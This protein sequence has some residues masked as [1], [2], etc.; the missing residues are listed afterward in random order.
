MQSKQSIVTIDKN[1]LTL[2][3]GLSSRQFA[4][5]KMGQYV[6]EP[7]VL[8]TQNAPNSF[9]TEE[10][11]FTDTKTLPVGK[12]DEVV[13]TNNTLQGTTLLSEIE[14]DSKKSLQALETLSSI[15]EWSI[16][17]N[18]QLP[19]CGPEGTIITKKG[20]LFLPFELFERSIL[21]QN[22]DTSSLLYGCWVNTALNDIDSWRFTLS[23]YTYTILT[24][25]KPF[26]EL[27]REKRT[28]DY[29]DNNFIPLNLMI[30]TNDTASQ[31]INHNLSLTNKAHTNIKPQKM[32][33]KKK[34]ITASLR[35][36]NKNVE[37]GS[38]A[39]PSQITDLEV[40]NIDSLILQSQQQF[41]EKK[42]KQLKKTRFLRKQKSKI[43]V[44]S[45]LFL[46]G[47]FI[48]GSIIKSNLS[49]PTTEGMTP[50]QVVQ[51]LYTSLN[52]LDNVTLDSCGTTDAVGNYSNMVATIYVSSKMREAYERT[53][54]FLTPSQW[55]GTDNPSEHFMFG[56]TNVTIEQ[57]GS[58][59]DSPIKGDKA[60]FTASF[61]TVVKQGVDYFEVTKSSDTITLEYG[62]KH[63][64]IVELKSDS[65]QIPV[66]SAQFIEDVTITR[67]L[68]KEDDTID[69]REQGI[70]LAE[71]LRESYPWVPSI[72]EV[73]AST[74]LIPNYLLEN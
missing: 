55:I 20:I 56:L 46:F 74:E 51:T 44:V 29:Y 21:A 19:N 23:C 53:S 70:L 38:V 68:I 34:S 40:Q 45:I 65:Q 11:R 15:V 31:I 36:T 32:K 59:N 41:I 62:R 67:M 66:D 8:I 57:R 27:D 17:N 12:S 50:T 5:A 43:I 14:N 30:K 58:S 3:T 73:S 18:V 9:T 39:L 13:L 16:E 22:K 49:K 52:T 54:P 72:Q 10:F 48:G 1:G 4:N 24:S 47:C 37:N 60:H 26:P 71:T 61:Y 33:E 63:W 25:K 6:T 7:G 35:E 69:T 28:E 64:Q 2:N 42:A